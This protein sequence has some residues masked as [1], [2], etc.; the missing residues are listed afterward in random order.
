MRYTACAALLL[1]MFVPVAF[2][3][4][5]PLKLVSRTY[6]AVTGCGDLGD[7]G[8][9]FDNNSSIY[10]YKVTVTVT[11]RNPIGHNQVC[12]RAPTSCSG[13]CNVP[14]GRPPLEGAL[15]ECGWSG[16]IMTIPKDADDLLFPCTFASCT[17][18]CCEHCDNVECDPPQWCTEA[19]FIGNM[20]YLEWSDDG[21]VTWTPFDIENPFLFQW[22]FGQTKSEKC[23][24]VP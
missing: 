13:D 12:T 7:G 16:F 1:V 15:C 19:K 4:D 18:Y 17:G 11:S 23:E 20:T 14:P 8:L 10:S 24:L 2:A 5:P 21:E 6:L 22:I 9:I 3:T